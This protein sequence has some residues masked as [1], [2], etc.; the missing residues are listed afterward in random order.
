M[1]SKMPT[2]II[3]KFFTLVFMLG[4]TLLPLNKAF[5][6]QAP[7]NGVSGVVKS[8]NGSMVE[9]TGG[10]T[11]D[12]SQA[13]LETELEDFKDTKISDIRPGTVIRAQGEA[14]L[15]QSN[16]GHTVFKATEA[17]VTLPQQIIVAAP[18]QKIDPER[19]VITVLNKEILIDSQTALFQRK[20]KKNKPTTF[21]SLGLGQKVTIDA[22]LQSD[23]SI[24]AKRVVEGL[25]PG[26]ISPIVV[27]LIQKVES[28]GV[29]TINGGFRVDVTHLVQT[30]PYPL[31]LTNGILAQLTIPEMFAM[32]NQ[33]PYMGTGFGI[34]SK[35][36]SFDGAFEKVDLVKQ[37]VT[38]FGREVQITSETKF[39]GYKNLNS[40][41]DVKTGIKDS[42]VEIEETPNGLVAKRLSC[43]YK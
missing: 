42:G 24:V 13:E 35:S 10:V 41:A 36:V 9:C 19:K 22:V 14:V 8:V 12:L 37:T 39:D 26:N 2:H 34:S 7:P 15:S 38:I 25:Y 43:Y 3:Y 4:L 32:T 20:K 11:V 40:L 27:G 29:I 33:D 21:V 1:L 23:G 17:K 30:F 6:Q 28:V 5:A 16:P 31:D 18:I